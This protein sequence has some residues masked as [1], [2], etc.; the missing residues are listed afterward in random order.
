MSDVKTLLEDL[1]LFVG[2]SEEELAK[3]TAV[4]HPIHIPAHQ[5]IIQQNTTGNKMYII[6]DGSVEVYVKGL[7]NQRSLVNLGK[8]QLFGEMAI[9]DQGYRSASVRATAEGADLYEVDKADFYALCQADNHIGFMFMRNLAIDLAF[10]LRHRNLT[11][12]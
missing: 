9:I 1:H 12:L 5:D 3:I 6:A 11:E 8:G 10:K 4:C 7:D 2:L